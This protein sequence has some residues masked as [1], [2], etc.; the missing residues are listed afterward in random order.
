MAGRVSIKP[1]GE[2][3]VASRFGSAVA[4]NGTLELLVTTAATRASTLR[5]RSQP[6]ASVRL[7]LYEDPT[8]S[9]DGTANAAVPVQ[10]NSSATPL[11]TVTHTPTTSSPGTLLMECIPD[12]EGPINWNLKPSEQYLVRLTNV[13]GG[14]TNL[15]LILEI[16]E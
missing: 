3:F 16:F 9:N 4:N 15:S 5:V 14:A 1:A 2:M 6:N 12:D 10:R 7:Q 8:A 13:S 11:A